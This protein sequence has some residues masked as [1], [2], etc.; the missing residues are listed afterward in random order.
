[1][2][3][4]CAYIIYGKGDCVDLK[5]NPSKWVACRNQAPG[6]VGSL[7]FNLTGRNR[8]DVALT[9]NVTHIFT[10][11]PVNETMLN[12]QKDDVNDALEIAAYPARQ[13]IHTF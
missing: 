2:I 10:P 13:F 6:S 5:I 12:Y 7:P 3:Y 1:M 8:T 4:Y 9:A 11:T